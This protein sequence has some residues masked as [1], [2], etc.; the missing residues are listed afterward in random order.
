MFCVR[1]P[2]PVVTG[3]SP[4]PG[5]FQTYAASPSGCRSRG[6]HQQCG[7]P[8][9]SYYSRIWNNKR[10]IQLK[11]ARFRSTVPKISTRN[12]PV[13]RGFSTSM[14]PLSNSASAGSSRATKDSRL[15]RV[16]I[17]LGSNMGDRI[18]MI[19]TACRLMEKR[20][21]RIQRTSSLFETAPMYVTEQGEFVNGVCEV[22]ICQ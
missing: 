17:A 22:S 20:G 1:L 7:S 11:D 10:D 15:R 3:F 19:E 12:Y 16:F 8:V 5:T 18:S 21:I 13:S 9:G 6:Y 2:F 14:N 4:I